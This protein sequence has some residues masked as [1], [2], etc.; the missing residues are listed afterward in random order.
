MRLPGARPGPLPRVRT[1]RPGARGRGGALGSARPPR[2]AGAELRAPVPAPLL[3]P[4]V[5][6]PPKPKWGL[7]A[8]DAD[9]A[10]DTFTIKMIIAWTSG[11]QK[12]GVSR[13]SNPRHRPGRA[14]DR[15]GLD[16]GLQ[17]PGDTPL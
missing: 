11:S 2:A 13:T 1:W 10:I 17:K 14:A 6:G 8:S 4:P 16:A 3:R 7:N 15:P 12:W 9:G 5:T